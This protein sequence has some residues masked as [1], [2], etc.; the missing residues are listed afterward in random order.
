MEQKILESLVNTAT[1]DMIE[2]PHISIKQKAKNLAKICLGRGN[3]IPKIDLIGWKNAIMALAVEDY[4]EYVNGKASLTNSMSAANTGAD[5]VYNKQLMLFLERWENAGCPIKSVEDAISGTVFLRKA[6]DERFKSAADRIFEYLINAPKDEAGSLLY[7]PAKPDKNIFADMLGM[8]CP[9]LALYGAKYSDERALK[10]AEV[11]ILNFV[12]YG[13]DDETLLPYHAYEIA[14][15]SKLGVVG[16]G[17]AVGWLLMG[18]AGYLAYAPCNRDA[19]EIIKSQFKITI[20]IVSKYQNESGLFE[21]KLDDNNEPTDTSATA[22]ILDS[23]ATALDVLKSDFQNGEDDRQ[24][25]NKYFEMLNKGVAG[26]EKF[27]QNGKVYG[28]QAECLG[29][30]LHPNVYGAYPWSL[31]PT[32]SVLS[33]AYR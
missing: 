9:F 15:D 4:D 32:I 33:K 25:M 3:E 17:R 10:T 5:S 14:S 21:W 23:L 6:D 24:Q 18:E 28:A 8:V 29:L 2:Y 27:I 13:I 26:I 16:W 30:G 7:N 1:E 22:M 31:G 11:Q 12:K 20:D 19:Y